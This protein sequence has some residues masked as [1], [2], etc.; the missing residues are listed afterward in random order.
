M[1]EQ[2]PQIERY[3]PIWGIFLLF[4]G[5]VFL[6]QTFNVLPWGLWGTLWRFWPV[7]LI[8]AGLNILMRRYNIWLV[9]ALILA[10]LLACL[11]ITIWQYGSSLPAGQ[12]TGS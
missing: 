3:V 2:K 9:S 4:L 5:I 1:S 10:L 6:L 11:G 8:I 12:A 7:L